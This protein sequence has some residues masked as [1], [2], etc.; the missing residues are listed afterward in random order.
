MFGPPPPPDLR[1]VQQQLD[2]LQSRMQAP[3]GAAVVLREIKG[4]L[5]ELQ[6]R[7]LQRSTAWLRAVAQ[8]AGI[9]AHAVTATV[10]GQGGNEGG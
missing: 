8:A 3:F 5:L 2:S 4:A 10:Q 9:A 1:R 6:D 7:R